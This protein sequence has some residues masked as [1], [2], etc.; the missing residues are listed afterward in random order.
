MP[1]LEQKSNCLQESTS[2]QMNDL[3]SEIYNEQNAQ[4]ISSR[5]TFKS[6]TSDSHFQLYP[7]IFYRNL[8]PLNINDIS[9]NRES[10]LNEFP[11]SFYQDRE[12]IIDH[13]SGIN[14]HVIYIPS[15]F[16]TMDEIKGNS[17]ECRKVIY[18]SYFDIEDID[19]SFS[20]LKLHDQSQ[21]ICENEEHSNS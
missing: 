15:W 1:N 21:I 4:D 12:L 11:I 9:E 19:L 13:S 5:D 10:D 16:D 17:N 18:D 8:S 14:E 2:T 20:Q 6:I 7:D 3:K